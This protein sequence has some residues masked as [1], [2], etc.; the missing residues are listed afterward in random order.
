M[1]EAEPPT[2]INNRR[3]IAF[4]NRHGIAVG[5]AGDGHIGEDAAVELAN[6]LSA[7]E[8]VPDYLELVPY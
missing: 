8:I 3:K 4:G 7:L 6:H 1:A 5:M 2:T